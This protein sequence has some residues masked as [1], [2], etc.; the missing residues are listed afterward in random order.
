M[1]HLL[2]L[3]LAALAG[4][5]ATLHAQFPLTGN[6]VD[7]ENGRPLAYVNIGIKW[8]NIG[9][10][11]GRDGAFRLDIPEGYADDTLTFSL[12]GYEERRL[13]LAE[14]EN[15]VQQHIQL[16]PKNVLLDEVTVSAHRPL[17]R[18]FG[19]KRRNLLIHFSD[20]MFNSDDS[21]EIG[22]LIRLGETQVKITALSLYVL[23]TRP[24]SATFRI[25]FYR[26]RDGRPDERAVEK[27]IVQRHA[28]EKGWLTFDLSEAGIRLSGDIVATLEFL[29]EPAESIP[30]ISYEVKLGGRSKSFYRRS[31]LGA[32]NTPPH[33][34][35]LNVTALVDRDAP[36]P[37]DEDIE[38]IPAFELT[39]RLVGDQYSIFVDLPDDYGQDTA[40]RYPVVYHL[41]G[42]AYFDHVR[43]AARAF[44]KWNGAVQPIVV[45]IGYGNAYLMD[46]LRVRDYTFPEALPTD[47]FVISGGAERFHAFL[48]EELIPHVDSLYRTDTAS[49]TIMGHSFGGYFV[50]Y[51][52]WSE[53]SA[54]HGP[55]PRFNS[56]IAASPSIGYRNGYIVNQLVRLPESAQP[57][58]TIPRHM[59]LTIGEQ[60][61]EPETESR[62][63]ELAEALRK[64][65]HIQL[66]TKVYPDTEHMGTAVSSFEDGLSSVYGNERE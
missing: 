63:I 31:S 50:L 22:Q 35:C 37:A 26:Y 42:N 65:L 1:K 47:S 40:K 33:H 43:E 14:L 29:P 58:K 57:G 66:K 9:T 3:L 52:L 36:E 6:V 45:G 46:S 21:F 19:I 54:D 30:P 24:D 18:R 62:F 16:V 48:T 64:R 25:N 39:S 56:Y 38:P 4:L 12:V 11:T 2:P 27:S 5:P 61:L 53:L 41:D 60:E 20:G 49:R 44:G 7:S 8:K 10:V 28:I 51:A 59:Y 32:W 15:G 23:A 34:Y 55:K 17:E 13:P